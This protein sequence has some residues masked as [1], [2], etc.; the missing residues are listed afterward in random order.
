MRGISWIFVVLAG[1]VGAGAAEAQS[2]GTGT[3]TKPISNPKWDAA[4][5][6]GLLSADPAPASNPYGGDWYFEGRYAASIGYYWTTHFKTELEA[7][8]SGQGER[9]VQLDSST[10]G[11]P[12]AYTYTAREHHTLRQ[13]SGRTV[14]QFFDNAWVH[15]YVFGGLTYDNDRVETSAAPQFY[16]PDP[17]TPGL[18]APLTPDAATRIVHRFGV[19]AGVGTKVYLTPNAFFNAALVMSYARPARTASVI[20][21]FGVDF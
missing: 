16:Y 19:N 15:P 20:G 7:T 2:A 14:W 21:G 3:D 9:Y 12:P 10:P 5:S 6:I 4:V 11:V 17:R 8:T 13:V 1:V 18:R